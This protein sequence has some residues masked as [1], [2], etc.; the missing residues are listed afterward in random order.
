LSIYSFQEIESFQH[1]VPIDA[2][3]VDAVYSN[4]PKFL[5]GWAAK[6]KHGQRYGAKYIAEY[7]KKLISMF[8]VGLQRKAEKMSADQMH[9]ELVCRHPNMLAL[10]LVTKINVLINCLSTRQKQ[11]KTGLHDGGANGQTRFPEDLFH[12][13]K[14]RLNDHGVES[15]PRDMFQSIRIKFSYRIGYSGFPSE[16]QIKQKFFALKIKLR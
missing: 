2:S 10:L 3:A 14:Q 12:A 1:L 15:R 8:E 6:R 13:M 16:A 11:C 4:L 7:E 9:Y 5:H